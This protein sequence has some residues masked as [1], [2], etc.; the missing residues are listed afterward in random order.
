MRTS[1]NANW[2]ILFTQPKLPSSRIE[3]GAE[4]ALGRELSVSI[5]EIMRTT[6]FRFFF[7][8]TMI[9]LLTGTSAASTYYVATSG[10]DTNDG[11][12]DHPWFSVKYAMTKLASNDTLFVRGGVYYEKAFTISGLSNV[13]VSAFPG[14]QVEITGG[15]PEFRPAPNTKWELSDG[16]INLYRSVNI[17]ASSSYMNAWL[18]DDNLHLVEYQVM[19][20]LRSTNYGPVQGFVPMYQGPGILLSNDAHLYIRL[21]NNPNDLVGPLGLPRAAVPAE[22]DP[23]K[24][25]ISVFFTK[26]LI[27]VS[28]SSSIK[29]RDLALSHAQYLFDITSSAANFEF[30]HCTFDYGR[31]AF[32]LRGTSTAPAAH[33]FVI[34]DCD[35]NNGLPEYV[36]WCDVKNK[37]QEVGEAY[38][39]F[40]SEAISGPASGFVIRNNTFHD[41]FD[42]MDLAAGTT[43]ARVVGNKFFRLRDDAVTLG[44]V[45]NVEIAECRD[46]LAHR[47]SG[48]G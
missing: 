17:Y 37:D 36:Y 30:D 2:G 5:I 20:N 22:L 33:D 44:I 42:A 27:T 1:W 23:N 18:L 29:F 28:N 25:S 3:E 13:V 16:A 47:R 19:D 24:H 7:N 41:S 32:V 26:T 48:V 40:Q 21:E 4:Q 39:E 10:L 34:H 15:M 14:E 12:K 6:F 35:F 9:L 43:N 31:Y 46:P 8:W 11:S 45:S 38:S